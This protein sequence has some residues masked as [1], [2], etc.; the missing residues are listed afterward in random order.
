MIEKRSK[1]MSY[2]VLFLYYR[3]IVQEVDNSLTN[4]SLFCIGNWAE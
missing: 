3:A 1:N 4:V 2:M